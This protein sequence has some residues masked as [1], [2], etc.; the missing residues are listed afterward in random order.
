MGQ[1][2]ALGITVACPASLF[3]VIFLLIRHSC[4]MIHS[5]GGFQGDHQYGPNVSTLMGPTVSIADGAGPSGE[6]VYQLPLASL[7][8]KWE[9]QCLPFLVLRAPQN[10]W[11]CSLRLS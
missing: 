4:N 7:S 1:K 6:H 2:L 9:L 10:H 11:L 3:A 8:V 5:P